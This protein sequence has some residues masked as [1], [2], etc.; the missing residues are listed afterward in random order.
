VLGGLHSLSGAP[1]EGTGAVHPTVVA[2]VVPADVRPGDTVSGSLVMDPKEYD[3]IPA[4][5]VVLME[6]P[7]ENG[8]DGKPTLRG[9]VADTGDGRLQPVDHGLKFRL[10]DKTFERIN[11]IRTLFRR[12]NNPVSI[13]TQQVPLGAAAPGLEKVAQMT[14]KASDFESP[15]VAPATSLNVIRGPFDGNSETTLIEVNGKRARVIAETPRATYYKLPSGLPPG[16]NK[17]ALRK[18]NRTATF[19]LYVVRLE[20][21]ADR[22]YLKQGETT[23][24]RAVVTGLQDMPDSMWHSGASPEL[25]DT[26]NLRALAPGFHP[27]AAGEAGTI[28]LTIENGSPETITILHSKNEVVVLTLD[29]KALA[30]GPYIY[31][32]TLRSRRSGSFAITAVLTAFVAPASGQESQK[33]K[34]E[35]SQPAP[36]KAA[37][38]EK[39]RAAV[40]D[41]EE[42]ARQARR[43]A[44]LAQRTADK[45][46]ALGLNATEAQKEADLLKQ[47]AAD[48]QSQA[49][50]AS[51]DAEKVA[52]ALP[53]QVQAS[54]LKKEATN[55]RAI[56][57]QVNSLL[58]KKRAE[59]EA[60]RRAALAARAAA[61]RA[62]DAQTVQQAKQ[63]A[64]QNEEQASTLEDEAG[65]LQDKAD[66]LEAK[67]TRLEGRVEELEKGSDDKDKKEKTQPTKSGKAALDSP[68]RLARDR[69]IGAAFAPIFYQG[70]GDH[71]RA[72]FITNFDFDGDWRG[73]NNWD[74]TD[75]PKYRIL[76]YVYFSVTETPTHFFIHYAV[77]HPRDYKG[78]LRKSVLLESAM[79]QAVGEIGGDPTGVTESVA[80]SH[81][82]DLEGCLVVARKHG[83]DPAQA[84]V[85]YVEAMA[86]NTYIK[87]RPASAPSPIGEIVEM[88]GEHPLMY[89]EA[90]GHGVSRY[91]GDEK[92]LKN[93]PLGILIYSYTG[94]AEDH[95]ATGSRMVGYDIVPIY[96]TLWQHAQQVPNETY[97]EA[98]DFSVVTALMHAL[99]GKDYPIK[100]VLGT[101]GVAFRGTV[102]FENK[103]RPPWGWYDMRERNRPR[104]EWFFDPAAVVARHFHLDS[105]D[106]STA[107][108]YNPY[109]GIGP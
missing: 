2:L 47:R 98:Y 64:A 7:L 18:G 83:E 42:V 62:Q 32:D 102:G 1:Q 8:E 84:T 9:V 74:H 80:L 37:E 14:G 16:P 58:T 92:Q 71:P 90:K 43:E 29:A 82:N 17:V 50:K 21:S 78:G 49:A 33:A 60:K 11:Q 23:E 12:G 76:A 81:E 56:I 77:Y 94:Q 104:G 107:Y 28:L 54:I 86:H 72:D 55:Y 93:A 25:A 51:Q 67:A 103:A 99:S 87:Y 91:T 26:A 35:G 65:D 52:A 6:L 40:E 108:T 105:K 31:T 5:R 106:F 100:E 44:E 24:F 45:T 63:E 46:K 96:A 48:L 68:E 38:L 30:K 109:L 19:T 3:K 79:K 53:P 10:P 88:K 61:A 4:V 101:L 95:E 70:L 20:M 85:E 41:K 22:L 66:R 89:C 34:E 97:G 75:D 69:Q 15:A 57:R 13:A 59:A 36:P 39:A 27:P 73:D